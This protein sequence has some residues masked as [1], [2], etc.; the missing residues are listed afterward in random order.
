ME[1]QKSV[2]AVAD[3]P[4]VT[5]FVSSETELNNA[6]QSANAGNI[7]NPIIDVTTGFTLTADVTPINVNMTIVSGNN[8]VVNDGGFSVLTIGN[9]AVVG[10]SLNAGGTGTVYI[11]G[12]GQD[13]TLLGLTG[14]VV[15]NVQVYN[16][17]V[18]QVNS[19]E[20]FQ[21][22]TV[23]V[24][25]ESTES[26]ITLNGTLNNTEPIQCNLGL[27][28]NSAGT[29]PQVGTIHLNGGSY[30]N[31]A[32]G[33]TFTASN[34]RVSIISAINSDGTGYLVCPGELKV[35]GNPTGM[36]DAGSING[37]NVQ[38]NIILETEGTYTCC[39]SEAP[40]CSTPGGTA[41]LIT[42]KSG[43]FDLG[44]TGTWNIGTYNQSGGFMRIT[45]P[46]FTGDAPLLNV[47]TSANFTGGKIQIN[48]GIYYLPGGT[49][50]QNIKIITAGLLNISNL[51]ELVVFQ[52]FPQGLVPSVNQVGND[53][54]LVLTVQS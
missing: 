21:T 12:A 49:T 26:G 35:I 37:V 8:V 5:C 36:N 11:N 25:A 31:I 42:N 50:N 54:Y 38:G 10:F 33:T 3:G 45:L 22:G 23:N 52:N 43:I 27:I 30:L 46:D 4:G 51:A 41:T 24:V 15:A 48:A 29:N 17:G 32:P 6:I 47:S 14:G 18:L 2:S 34:I 13:S 28:S 44:T 53:L 16:D 9:G 1:N 7:I 20:T 19:G 39:S 40:P